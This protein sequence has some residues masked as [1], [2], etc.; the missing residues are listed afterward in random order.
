M[1]QILRA[2]DLSTA[3]RAVLI[4][5]FLLFATSSSHATSVQSQV[6]AYSGLLRDGREHP[7]NGMQTTLDSALTWTMSRL[8]SDFALY[9][10]LGREVH[11]VDNALKGPIP[12]LSAIGHH[13][14][15]LTMC[16]VVPSPCESCPLGTSLAR[17]LYTQ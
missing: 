15:S 6:V 12:C 2:R 14:W 4:S 1:Q 13:L 7:G 10:K 3:A 5:T 8:R 17:H 11:D 16:V 9:V